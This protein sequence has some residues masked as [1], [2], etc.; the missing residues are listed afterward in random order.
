MDL[1]SFAIKASLTEEEMLA[2]I[3]NGDERVLTEEEVQ[4]LAS[5]ETNNVTTEPLPEPFVDGPYDFKISGSV[6]VAYRTE[7]TVGVCLRTTPAAD[8][9]TLTYD[10]VFVNGD[11][12]TKR[13]ALVLSDLGPDYIYVKVHNIQANTNTYSTI[14]DY[15]NETNVNFIPAAYYYKNL[16]IVIQQA[17][18]TYNGNINMYP[19]VRNVQ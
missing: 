16:I 13:S 6:Q 2:D 5:Y 19:P 1:M 8:P 11:V 15:V 9:S 12:L 18:G 4:L 3:F 17:G 7:V 14:L 10:N